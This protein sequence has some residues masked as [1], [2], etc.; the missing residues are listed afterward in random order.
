[1][2]FVFESYCLRIF[3]YQEIVILNDLES[4][5][6]PLSF[7]FFQSIHIKVTSPKRRLFLL[8]GM[9]GGRKK[10]GKKDGR[11]GEREKIK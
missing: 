10:E 6:S 4:F 8:G 2:M 9:E 5:P 11:N 1:M 7:Y 3:L